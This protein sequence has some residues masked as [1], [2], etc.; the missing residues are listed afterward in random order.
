MRRRVVAV[1]C[2]ACGP[3]CGARVRV[4]SL[5]SAVIDGWLSLFGWSRWVASGS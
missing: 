2:A 5:S 4:R 3:L 1:Q